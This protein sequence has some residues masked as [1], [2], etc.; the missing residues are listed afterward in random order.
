MPSF[1]TQLPNLQ[2]AGPLVEVR[3]WVGSPVEAA[4]RK[5]GTKIP[6]PV[7][8]KGLI[9]TGATGSVIQP[10][11]VRQ[12][13]L[14]PIGVVNISTPSSESVPCYQYSVRLIF[15]N[16]VLVEAIAIEAPLK[17]QQI[18]CLVGRDVLAHGVFVYTGYINQFTLSF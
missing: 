17:G 14:E 18:G 4:L 8:A 13:G 1:T 11:I 2:A 16:N 5:A 7:Q 9:D 6:G 15:P 3:V 12:L 10:G